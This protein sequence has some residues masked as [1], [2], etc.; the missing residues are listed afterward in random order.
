MKQKLSIFDE[1]LNKLEK[2]VE[3]YEVYKK[4]NLSSNNGNCK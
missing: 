3:Y 1:K 4:S 2:S